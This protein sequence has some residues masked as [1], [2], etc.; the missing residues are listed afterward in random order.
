VKFD[1]D[2]GKLEFDSSASVG[3]I[4]AFY[5][6]LLK[7]QG[8]K[9]EPSV[10]NKSNMVVMEFAKGGKA[11]SFTAMQMGP[12]VNVTADGSG[13]VMAGARAGSANSQVANGP[14]SGS[15]DKAVVE[16]LEAEPD[17]ALPVPKRHIMSS[18]GAANLPGGQTPFRRE[19][20]ASVP[21][22]INSVLAFYRS[23]LTKRGWK[24]AAGHAVVKAD[25]VQLAFASPEGPAVLKLGRQNGQTT[26]DLAQ[27]NPAAAAKADVMPKAG[28]ARLM[29]GN[30]GGSEAAVTI[31]KQTIR[32]AAGAGGPQSRKGPMVELPPGKYQ[33]SLKVAG[34][35]ARSNQIEIAADDSWGL[36]IAPNGEVMPLQM[37]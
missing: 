10:I 18:M 17:S 21:A 8:W 36:M 14:S 25:Q 4:A 13:L 31:N 2:G 20:E 11:L 5:R 26:I 28:L 19:L 12:K 7:S 37:Y 34:G 27:K 9:E 3:A 32:I 16:N 6:G 15:T 30:M 33:Y 24:E 1:G 23:E 29:F 22:E 35:P